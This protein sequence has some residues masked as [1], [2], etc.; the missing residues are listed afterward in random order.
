M[1]KHFFIFTLF[2]LGFCFIGVRGVLAATVFT[3]TPTGSNTD[4]HTYNSHY[5]RTAGINTFQAASDGI[6]T[7]GSST[8]YNRDDQNNNTYYTNYIVK[9]GNQS[10]NFTVGYASTSD[11]GFAYFQ[12]NANTNGTVSW[13]RGSCANVSQLFTTC[14][15]ANTGSGT[16]SNVGVNQVDPYQITYRQNGTTQYLYINGT[17]IASGTSSYSN[18]RPEFS[19]PFGNG[20]SRIVQIRITDDA[21]AF[22][23]TAATFAVDSSV[24]SPSAGKAYLNMSGNLG[25]TSASTS[26]TISI[27][28]K[29][30]KNPT[31]I[32]TY[33]TYTSSIPVAH[34]DVDA[35][36]PRTEAQGTL[37][38]GGGYYVGY[39]Y[40]PTDANWAAKG[41]A[42]PYHAGESCRYPISYQVFE[43]PACTIWFDDSGGAH[44][45]C[46]LK[47]VVRQGQALSSTSPDYN[48][49]FVATPSATQ[50]TTPVAEPDC[51]SDLLCHLQ[52][53]LNA[54]V[55]FWF[56]PDTDE[57]GGGGGGATSTPVETTG[58]NIALGFI[59]FLMTF[60]GF[61]FYFKRQ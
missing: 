3:D 41:I 55:Q 38:N 40:T 19:I 16:S 1:I 45:S 54:Q 37:D 25:Y 32:D 33:P 8:I 58:I 6:K 26:A 20:N 15:P 27:S 2:L 42:V 51:A 49:T 13:S 21:P 48:P 11:T 4:L 60:F 30:Q 34:V 29:C 52:L 28:E 43:S 35:R 5:N 23:E 59:I 18:G 24:A 50:S 46:P 17:L 57:S 36:N 12:I 7:T 9:Q 53:W 10:A 44:S 61:I 31:W 22:F 39:G 14:T 47:R 56:I